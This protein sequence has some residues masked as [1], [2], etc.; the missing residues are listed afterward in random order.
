[1]I[2]LTDPTFQLNGWGDVA[3][4][5]GIFAT[6][7]SVLGGGL[8][9]K[10]NGRKSKIDQQAAD[11]Q[12]SDRLIKLIETEANKKVEI[13]RTEFRLE[14]A[15]LKLAHS[16]ELSSLRQDF[17]KQLK[18]LRDERDTYRCDHALVCSWRSKAIP[19]PSVLQITTES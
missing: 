10:I 9:I 7:S 13:V 19:P 17:E 4:L 12:A 14:I 8:G 1:V 2:H 3:I 11:D 15:E 6:L 5:C 16:S 18:K